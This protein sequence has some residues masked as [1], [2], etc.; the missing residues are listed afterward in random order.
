[1]LVTEPLPHCAAA[2]ESGHEIGLLGCSF[3]SWVKFQRWSWPRVFEITTEPELCLSPILKHMFN[4]RLRMVRLAWT[5]SKSCLPIHY[6]PLLYSSLLV[7]FPTEK[8]HLFG[9]TLHSS[10]ILFILI[11]FAVCFMDYFY[12]LEHRRQPPRL[13]KCTRKFSILFSVHFLMISTMIVVR[14]FL[15]QG[16]GYWI[17]VFSRLSTS[18]GQLRKQS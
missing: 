5:T 1:M 4:L 9:F 14:G 6:R 2:Q 18:I 13:T 8:F 3:L 15:G 12:F 17:D 10:Y 11:A 16:Q 7:S